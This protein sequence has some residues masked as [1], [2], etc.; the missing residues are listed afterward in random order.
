M[1]AILAVGALDLKKL[2]HS[3][4]PFNIGDANQMKSR[5]GFQN[6]RGEAE[7]KE[8]FFCRPPTDEDL[9]PASQ[10]FSSLAGDIPE[11]VMSTFLT[12]LVWF[13]TPREREKSLPTFFRTGHGSYSRQGGA[14]KPQG[15]RPVPSDGR[16]REARGCWFEPALLF[17]P[18]AAPPVGH[19]DSP[20][21]EKNRY[22]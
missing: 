6:M 2:A 16:G 14:A 21:F 15:A 19:C 17:P 1:A 8:A 10:T 22:V 11:V 9:R 4:P 20:S 3:G 7:E 18:I 12:R 5:E 13:F